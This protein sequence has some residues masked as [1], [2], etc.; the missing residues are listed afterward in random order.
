MFFKRGD[1]TFR[2]IDVVVVQWDYLNVHLV[3]S[4][5]VLNRFGALVVHHI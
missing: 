5:V 3:G 1:G 4:D 2:S